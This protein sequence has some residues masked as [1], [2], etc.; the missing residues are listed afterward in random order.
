MDFH[1]IWREQS[2]V[3]PTIRDRFGIKS[4]LD[5]L[6]GGKLVTFA[7]WQMRIRILPPSSRAFKRLC[8]RFSTPMNSAAM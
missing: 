5:Y 2:A 8:G 6:V 4:A 3:T 1:K 7:R